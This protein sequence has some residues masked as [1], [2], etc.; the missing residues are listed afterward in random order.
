MVY[1]YVLAE[2]FY[3]PSLSATVTYRKCIKSTL[4]SELYVQD[5]NLIVICIPIVPKS[6]TSFRNMIKSRLAIPS[7]PETLTETSM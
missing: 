7:E 2:N 4:P 1:I 5:S 6:S 3:A